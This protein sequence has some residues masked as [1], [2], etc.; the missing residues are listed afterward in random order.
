MSGENIDACFGRRTTGS[1]NRNN[2]GDSADTA[3]IL[4]QD[5]DEVI[6]DV[7]ILLYHTATVSPGPS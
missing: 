4:T 6:N 5:A 3:V 7:A 2:S 1:I